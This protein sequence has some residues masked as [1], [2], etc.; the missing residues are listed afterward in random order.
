MSWEPT[1]PA[2]TSVR[3][4]ATKNLTHYELESVDLIL[5]NAG[6]GIAIVAIVWLSGFLDGSDFLAH[7]RHEGSFSGADISSQLAATV[8]GTDDY[9]TAIQRLA[10]QILIDDGQIPAGSFT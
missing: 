9:E 5:G 3:A 4:P 1:S 6:G 2:S 7:E 8:T 10:W